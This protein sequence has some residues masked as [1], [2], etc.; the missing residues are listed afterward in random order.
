MLNAVVTSTYNLAEQMMNLKLWFTE[1]AEK[2][3]SL[4]PSLLTA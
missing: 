2:E 4:R 3:T 1:G